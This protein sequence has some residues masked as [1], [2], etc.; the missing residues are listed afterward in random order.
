MANTKDSPEKLWHLPSFDTHDGSSRSSKSPTKDQ[1]KPPTAEEINAI[2]TSAF[3]EGKAEGVQQ[4]LKEGLVQAEK[5]YQLLQQSFNHLMDSFS[6]PLKLNQKEVED[7]VIRLVTLLSKQIIKRELK[8]DPEQIIAVVREGIKLLPSYRKQVTVTC[9]PDDGEVI[10]KVFANSASNN[11]QINDDPSITRGGCKIS[12]ETSMVDASLEH[13]LSQ[14][15]Q[16]VFGDQR[17]A[18]EEQ[19]E[20]V[21][22]EPSAVPTP[23]T[24]DSKYYENNLANHENIK[25][26]DEPA[27][28]SFSE[29]ELT[30]ETQKPK[31]DGSNND[32]AAIDDVNE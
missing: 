20:A 31:L 16:H 3:E 12:T 26:S 14:L 21:T 4:G 5:N 29:Q 2:R 17:I 10:R 22:N 9:H 7:D 11:W 6:E 19:N 32:S 18:T 8:S 28:P 27:K 15:F 24:L 30:A 13:R 25:S 1:L 23:K